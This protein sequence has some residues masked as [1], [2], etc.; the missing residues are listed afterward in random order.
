MKTLKIIYAILILNALVVSGYAA[1]E[2]VCTKDGLCFEIIVKSPLNPDPIDD[3]KWGEACFFES[4]FRKLQWAL[5]Y[6]DDKE[7]ARIEH[8]KR[9]LWGA[10]IRVGGVGGKELEVVSEQADGAQDRA[11]I[12]SVDDYYFCTIRVAIGN[13]QR[14][15]DLTVRKFKDM[16]L[17]VREV[18]EITK[19]TKDERPILQ[20]HGLS[21]EKKEEAGEEFIDV[22]SAPALTLD[23]LNAAYQ[24]MEECRNRLFEIASGYGVEGNHEERIGQIE[25]VLQKLKTTIEEFEKVKLENEFTRQYYG[26]QLD[27][28]L[29]EIQSLMQYIKTS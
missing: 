22:N 26:N 27:K 3:Q 23:L 17:A 9:L 29:K 16:D 11:I 18:K 10:K 25:V 19:I 6:D 12:S 20:L 28:Q 24:E 2:P 5:L 8:M 4:V 13:P 21:S 1:C 7:E 14:I 15:F